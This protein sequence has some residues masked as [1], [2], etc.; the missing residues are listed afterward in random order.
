MS[1]VVVSIESVAASIPCIRFDGE[2]FA[3]D[4]QPVD[5]GVIRGTVSVGRQAA[6]LA[7]FEYSR[8]L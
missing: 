7:S 8:I 1:E 4:K 2:L 5:N 3:L 6:S